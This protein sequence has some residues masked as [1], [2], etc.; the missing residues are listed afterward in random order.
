MISTIG[1]DKA[2]VLAVLY[3]TARPQGMGFLPYDAKPMTVEEAA[4]I[5]KRTQYF[6]YLKGRVLKV[7]LRGEGE[8][9][10]GLYDRDNGT[11]CGYFAI[12]FLRWTGEVYGPEIE[13]VH[14]N[15]L[16]TAAVDATRMSF[17]ESHMEQKGNIATLTLG[18]DDAGGKLRDAVEKATNEQ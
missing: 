18:A 9:E 11:G 16:T 4:D 10:E 13:L 7:D 6:D 12:S 1:L 3:N 14:K 8:F 5:L 15:G 2:K 17:T